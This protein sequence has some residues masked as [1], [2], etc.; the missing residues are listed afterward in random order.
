MENGSVTVIYTQEEYYFRAFENMLNYSE[1]VLRKLFQARWEEKFK[2]NWDYWK[3][4][5]TQV[6]KLLDMI[7]KYLNKT[8]KSKL[9]LAC[10]GDWDMTLLCIILTKYWDE[11][12]HQFIN[13][14]VRRLK[15]FR[16]DM[17]HNPSK[18]I[19]QEEYNQMVTEFSEHLQF[20]DVND[21]DIKQIIQEAESTTTIATKN[22]K[23]TIL[24]KK[25]IIRLL[26][27]N[28]KNCITGEDR[29]VLDETVKLFKSVVNAELLQCVIHGGG[30]VSVCDRQ[31]DHHDDADI[32]EFYKLRGYALSDIA[33]S[34][35]ERSF[36]VSFVS[37]PTCSNLLQVRM[38]NV[39]YNRGGYAAR[40]NSL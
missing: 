20:L 11:D 16:N 24:Q 3:P 25:Q 14:K 17:A 38:S 31:Q 4:S 15:C 21:V 27:I 22:D 37:E 1:H 12:S 19:C 35:S 7:K 36:D 23:A 30:G 29:F 9:E 10:M 28:F 33:G 26:L 5:S 34:C 8:Q 39:V 40:V 6:E 32:S 2:E 18:M 13:E